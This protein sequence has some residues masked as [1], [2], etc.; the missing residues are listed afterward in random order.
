MAGAGF[1]PTTQAN[2]KSF[3]HN[4]DTFLLR[5]TDELP[6]FIGGD[7]WSPPLYSLS[8]STLFAV[9]QQFL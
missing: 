3:N 5:S 9:H 6:Y 4:P 2:G 8:L 7:F 1:E